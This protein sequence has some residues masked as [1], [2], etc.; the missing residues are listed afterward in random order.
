VCLLVLFK[1]GLELWAHVGFS[2]AG[3]PQGGL[4]LEGYCNSFELIC[5]TFSR[6]FI[7]LRYVC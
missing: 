4:I 2:A 7:N 3:W 1:E 5:S 6:C